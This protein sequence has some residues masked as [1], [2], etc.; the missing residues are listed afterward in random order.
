MDLSEKDLKAEIAA[1]EEVIKGCER[2]I[3]INEI[4]LKAFKDALAIYNK[5]N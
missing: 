3:K 4:V 5:R 2:T 1:C